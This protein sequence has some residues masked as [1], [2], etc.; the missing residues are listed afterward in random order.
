[1][2]TMHSNEFLA[3]GAAV[4]AAICNNLIDLEPFI[5]TGQTVIDDDV[6]SGNIERNSE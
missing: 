3:R 5:L 6:A 2:R 1:M 4:K